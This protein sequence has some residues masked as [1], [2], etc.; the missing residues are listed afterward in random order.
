MLS[1]FI[2]DVLSANKATSVYMY[3][4]TGHMKMITQFLKENINSFEQYVKHY[5]KK[6]MHITFILFHIL[7]YFLKVF[8]DSDTKGFVK[9]KYILYSSDHDL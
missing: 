5:G 3:T 4:P 7:P 8:K 9:G 2:T 6:K 1:I